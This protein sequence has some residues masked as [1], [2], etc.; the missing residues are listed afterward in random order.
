MPPRPNMDT[1]KKVEGL[2]NGQRIRHLLR[3]QDIIKISQEQRTCGALY[4]L[5]CTQNRQ[6][7]YVSVCLNESSYSFCVK[8]FGI[9]RLNAVPDLGRFSTGQLPPAP[10][11]DPQQARRLTQD[12][13]RRKGRQNYSYS[14]Q[15]VTRKRII[16]K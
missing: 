8:Q 16:S 11:Q 6:R 4:Y 5:N 14:H 12:S 1:F 7:G 13:C 10:A 15:Q 2:G 3:S 9:G